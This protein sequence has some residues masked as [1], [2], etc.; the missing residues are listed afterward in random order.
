MPNMNVI[1]ALNDAH[2][3]AMRADSDAGIVKRSGATNGSSSAIAEPACARV[4]P[5]RSDVIG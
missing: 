4:T 3:V 1:Q 5:R 2:K